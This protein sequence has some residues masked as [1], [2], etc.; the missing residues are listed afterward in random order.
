M[1]KQLQD[2]CRKIQSKQY[3]ISVGKQLQ[4]VCRKDY[5]TNIWHCLLRVAGVVNEQEDRKGRQTLGPQ[6]TK[7]RE[8]L[9]M[10]GMVFLLVQHNRCLEKQ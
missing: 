4:D 8:Q 5:Y 1:G 7:K 2:V 10:F 3:L 6:A 9:A